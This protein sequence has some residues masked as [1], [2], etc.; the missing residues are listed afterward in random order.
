MAVI[1]CLMNQSICSLSLSLFLSLFSLSLFL[2][3]F[4][5]TEIHRSS[6]PFFL[7]VQ[8]SATY[9]CKTTIARCNKEQMLPCSV[10]T[11]P[12]CIS[13]VFLTEPSQWENR[14]SG[15]S[16][17]QQHGLYPANNSWSAINWKSLSGKKIGS[18]STAMTE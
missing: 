5:H 9:L 16:G 2:S 10:N 14:G 13:C 3:M 8:L 15:L 1:N 6:H 18:W 12:S 7:P 17:S 4:T 11:S